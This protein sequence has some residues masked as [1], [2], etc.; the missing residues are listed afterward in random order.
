MA[1][2][3]RDGL[4][5]AR[6]RIGPREMSLLEG[7]TGEEPAPWGPRA[8][9]QITVDDSLYCTALRRSRMRGNVRCQKAPFRYS[10]SSHGQPVQ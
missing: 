10:S 4:G 8:A 3:G 7:G 1:F 6:Y 2:T 9:Y 5:I